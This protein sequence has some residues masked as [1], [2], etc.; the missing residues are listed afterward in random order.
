MR[1]NFNKPRISVAFCSLFGMSMAIFAIHFVYRFLVVTGSKHLQK[2]HPQKVFGLILFTIL[3]G[4]L[5]TA[6]MYKFL[7]P[8]QYSDILLSLEYLKPRRL[9]ISNVDYVG[10]HF[11]QIDSNGVSFINW[12]SMFAIVLMTVVIFLSFST[13]FICGHKIYRNMQEMMSLRSSKDHNLQSQLFWA[14]VFQTLIPVFLMHIP[15]SFGFLFSMFN[16][17]TELL[18]EIPA[19]TIFMYPA[20]D[21]LPNFFI[22]KNYRNAILAFFGCRRPTVVPKDSSRPNSKTSGPILSNSKLGSAAH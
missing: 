14:L 16:S 2:C 7:G 8:N 3:V 10:A 18:G 4:C 9:N 21:P 20:L 11:H 1:L 6:A 17:S 19:T 5:W 13:V 12:N 22:I 15:A